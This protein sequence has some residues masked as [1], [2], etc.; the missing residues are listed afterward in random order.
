VNEAAQAGQEGIDILEI[1]SY[2][3]DLATG[4]VGSGWNDTS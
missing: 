4:K 3:A 2:P 1:L